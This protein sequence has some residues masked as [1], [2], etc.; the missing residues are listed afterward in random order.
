MTA[1]R[2]DAAGTVTIRMASDCEHTRGVD[3][4]R[5]RAVHHKARVVIFDEPTATLTPEE[6]YHFFN[7][8]GRLKKQG[9]SIIFISHALEEALLLS[10]RITVLRDGE[11][12]VT[13][14]TAKFTR[15]SI[16]QAMVG[17]SL[18][19]ELYCSR[20]GKDTLL[21]GSGP[22]GR[23]VFFARAKRPSD[24]GERWRNDCRC[25]FDLFSGRCSASFCLLRHEGR[26]GD[27]DEIPVDR[28]D[29]VRHPG[30][31]RRTGLFFDSRDQSYGGRERINLIPRPQ[32]DDSFLD[33]QIRTSQIQALANEEVRHGKSDC[34]AG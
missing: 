6:K 24:R 25:R 3:F 29:S 11:T 18:S 20:K 33:S 32:K 28:M 31:C 17:R 1:A 4:R 22:G 30:K 12:V 2:P 23:R 27:H 14:V 16:I 13:D 8:V 21:E 5:A 7:L 9:V 19:G 34:A 10:D 15:D 26:S